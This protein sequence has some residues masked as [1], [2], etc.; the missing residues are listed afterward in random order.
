MDCRKSHFSRIGHDKITANCLSNVYLHSLPGE[1]KIV[2]K[3]LPLVGMQKV[4]EYL[5]ELRNRRATNLL[6]TIGGAAHLREFYLHF[7]KVSR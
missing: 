7:H 2:V 5:S 6:R 1:C 4:C 3:S